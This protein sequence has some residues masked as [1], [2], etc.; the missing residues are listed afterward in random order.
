MLTSCG[1]LVAAGPRNISVKC[2]FFFFKGTSLNQ[3]ISE[4]IYQSSDNLSII[5]G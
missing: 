2:F 4:N 3:L 1:P 5:K